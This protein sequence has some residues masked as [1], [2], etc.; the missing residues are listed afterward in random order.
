MHEMDDCL[1]AWNMHHC[2]VLTTVLLC[3]RSTVSAD[4]TQPIQAHNPPAQAPTPLA[5]PPHLHTHQPQPPTPSPPTTR[6]T[7][8]SADAISAVPSGSKAYSARCRP[9]YSGSSPSP[10]PLSGPRAFF[11]LIIV[12]A[13]HIVENLRSHLVVAQEV[14]VQIQL[15]G[16]QFTACA[17]PCAA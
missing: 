14:P 8:S 11:V 16:N 4:A 3:I 12:C 1:L 5:A 13:G 7:Q 10:R 9:E 2:W 6:T 15:F 17:H